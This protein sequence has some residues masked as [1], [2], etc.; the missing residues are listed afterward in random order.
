MKAKVSI[1][2][3]VYNVEKYIDKCLNSV[4]NQ[5]LKD[6]EIIVIDDETPDNSMNIVN[7]YAKKDSRIVVLKEKNKGQAGARNYGIKKSSGE[8]IMFVDSDDY[9]SNDICEKLYNK[10]TEDNSDIVYSN[11]IELDEKGD[12]LPDIPKIEL[13][14]VKKNYIVNQ[15]GPCNKIVKASVIKDNNLYFPETIRAYEDIAVV[16]SWLLHSNNVSYL[17]EAY[18]YY[19]VR[20]GST[21]HQI[22]YDKKLEDIFTSLNI[23]WEG[24]NKTNSLEK[25]HSEIEWVFIANLLHAAT[26]RFLKFDNYQ[27]N[28]D[29][30]IEAMKDKFPKWNKNKYYKMKGIKFKIVCNLIYRNKIK[31]LKMLLKEG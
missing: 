27:K 2:I 10:A 5:T 6:I 17:N 30:V 11:C 26:L 18:Y 7:K 21:M 22:T 19:L 12:R 15:F 1:I 14:D 23:F 20:D 4:I 16:S 31:L 8:Y 9:V 3:P 24:F 28:I 25:Y 13:K 29:R